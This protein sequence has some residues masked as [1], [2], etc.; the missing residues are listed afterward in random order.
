MTSWGRYAEIFAYDE[1][2]GSVQPRQSEPDPEV[3]VMRSFPVALLGLLSLIVTHDGARAT[4]DEQQ[5]AAIHAQTTFVLQGTPGFAHFA[6]C[7]AEQSDAAS[8][9]GDD[10]PDAIRRRAPR[11]GAE[12]LGNPEIDQGFGLS[13]T[14][15]AAGFP[16]AEAYK[17]GKSTPISGSSALFFRQ[18]I[19]LGGEPTGVAAAANQLGGTRPREPAGADRR[20]VRR[21]R[22]VR[23]QRYAHDPR[24]DFL[25]W[26]VVDAG[27]FDYAA[28]AWGYSYRRRAAN[29]MRRHG[30]CGSARSTCRKIPN[31]ETLE[32][33]F[34]QYQLDA[35]IE[36]RHTHRRP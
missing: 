19:G 7:W 4:D 9:Q 28:D 34:G 25:N 30:R 11:Q 1:T 33:G 3:M 12:A 24:G 22:R 21:R 26:S 10:R 29:G 15:G 6:Y 17:V 36:H 31:G 16:S 8:A 5:N 20:Q 27:S 14:L 35:E 18:T 2:D 23:H 13:N 32:S